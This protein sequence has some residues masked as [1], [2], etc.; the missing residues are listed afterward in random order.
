MT[1]PASSCPVWPG[2]PITAH[3]GIPDPCVATG[4]E[5]EIAV[6]FDD[7]YGMRRRRI[8]LFLALPIVKLDRLVLISHL[9][10]IGR[11]EGATALAKTG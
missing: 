2:Q 11:G 1:P 9:K 8:D 5:A 4:S 3:W 7:A 6:A 10:E